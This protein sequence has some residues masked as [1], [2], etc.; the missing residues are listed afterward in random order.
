[1]K[2]TFINHNQA[3]NSWFRIPLVIFETL[4]APTIESFLFGS[5]H[6]YPKHIIFTVSTA[7]IVK[8]ETG[9]QRS[10]SFQIELITFTFRDKI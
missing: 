6:F 2:F 1:M 5:V 4:L 9:P 8:I 3:S 10:P 7:F